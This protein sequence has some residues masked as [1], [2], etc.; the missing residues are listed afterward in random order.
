MA[1]FPAI[2]QLMLNHALLKLVPF[3]QHSAGD[4][5]DARLRKRGASAWRGFRPQPPATATSTPAPSVSAGPPTAPWPGSTT[6]G[7]SACSLR[8]LASTSRALNRRERCQGLLQVHKALTVA[9]G[10]TRRLP[11]PGVGER[12]TGDPYLTGPAA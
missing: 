12:P 8:R 1:S 11:S 10:I 3:A 6:S 4:G 7:F 9:T 2:P 5:A